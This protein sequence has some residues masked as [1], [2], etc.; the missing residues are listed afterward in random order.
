[1]LYQEGLE[2]LVVC[3]DAVVHDDK[4]VVGIGAVRVRVEVRGRA[5]RGPPRVR[6]PDVVRQLLLCVGALDRCARARRG[7]GGQ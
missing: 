3:D 7:G 5:V 4:L 6:N 2:L 1:M